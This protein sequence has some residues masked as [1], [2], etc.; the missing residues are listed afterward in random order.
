MAAPLQHV[1]ESRMLPSKMIEWLVERAAELGDV[2]KSWKPIQGR[3]DWHMDVGH[4]Q[5]VKKSGSDTITMIKHRRS[6]CTKA[7][8]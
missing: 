8:P 4:F 5:L 2:L 6:D 3:V 7:L 1:P